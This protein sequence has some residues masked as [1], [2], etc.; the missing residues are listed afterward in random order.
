MSVRTARDARTTGRFINALSQPVQEC[1]RAF[2]GKFVAVPVERG[3]ALHHGAMLR[4][5]EHSAKPTSPSN[6]RE[7]D[8][9]QE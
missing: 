3:T 9:A 8:P 4:A 2:D 7:Q 1:E 6:E 5:G